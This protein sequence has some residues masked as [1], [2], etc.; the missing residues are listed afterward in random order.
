MRVSFRFLNYQK[1]PL[2][3]QPSIL[4]QK[5]GFSLNCHSYQVPMSLP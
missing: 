2:D 5:K 1:L 4:K 3:K